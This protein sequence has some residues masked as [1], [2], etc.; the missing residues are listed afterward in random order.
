MRI[1]GPPVAGFRYSTVASFPPRRREQRVEP[2]LGVRPRVAQE[3]RVQRVALLARRRQPAGGVEL[4]GEAVPPHG[5]LRVR[6]VLEED[7]LERDHQRQVEPV[8]P[9]H[10]LVAVVVVVVPHPVRREDQVAGLHL[11]RV[12]VDR[13][14]DARARHHEADR[15][16]SVPV[17]RRVLARA[18][19]LDRA[20][21]G[22]ARE[23]QPAEPRVREREH[24]PV[25]AALDRD[26]LAGALGEGEDRVPLPE[27]RDRVDGI[28]TSGINLRCRLQSACRSWAASAPQNSS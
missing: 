17:R 1:A 23:R 10:R 28:G 27:P 21:E 19:V 25:A 15:R 8:E 2:A 9:H 18:E 16:G 22:R 7:R 11:A 20:P 5:L 14:V 24:A 4:L 13:R 6:V 12:A 26:D 3:R